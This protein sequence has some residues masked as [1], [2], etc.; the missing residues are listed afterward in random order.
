M[1]V[2]EAHQTN[3]T[4]T[5]S[6]PIQAEAQVIMFGAEAEVVD[7]LGRVLDLLLE[8]EGRVVRGR[9]VGVCRSQRVEEVVHLE[10]DL[11]SAF[12]VRWYCMIRSRGNMGGMVVDGTERALC[13]C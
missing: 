7:L 12:R 1:E 3:T 10:S 2:L 13:V 4:S 8:G 6:G 11:E 9:G 5:N